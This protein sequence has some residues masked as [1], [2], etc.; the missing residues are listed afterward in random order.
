MLLWI[1][2]LTFVCHF[3][4]YGQKCVCQIQFLCFSDK[5]ETP[6]LGV[7]SKRIISFSDCPLEEE[8][9]FETHFTTK[10]MCILHNLWFLFLNSAQNYYRRNH[11][12]T[13]P[14]PASWSIFLAFPPHG[15][16]LCFSSHRRGNC[17]T[18]RAGH[19]MS[20]WSNK[21]FLW[22]GCSG[23]VSEVA[24]LISDLALPSQHCFLC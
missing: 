17:S 20:Q 2:E 1:K 14:P 18:G 12:R 13:Y 3:F 9:Q 15:L 21:L 23:G 7:F 11:R 22:A 6:W 10:S 16:L 8:N 19:T 24:T 4:L 5:P